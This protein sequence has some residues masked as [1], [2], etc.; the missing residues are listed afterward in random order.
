MASTSAKLYIRSA[1]FLHSK[2]KTF[3]KLLLYQKKSLILQCR[4]VCI[5][6]HYI[7]NHAYEQERPVTLPDLRLLFEYTSEANTESTYKYFTPVRMIF[8][9]IV[10]GL[11]ERKYL[12]ENLSLNSVPDFLN[13]SEVD[14]FVLNRPIMHKT[15]VHALD[16]FLDITQDGSHTRKKVPLGV[17]DY[18]RNRQ[19]TNL[20]KSVLYIIMDV[21]LWYKDL[22]DNP[23]D[24][25]NLWKGTY[26]A[27]GKV[28]AKMNK[29]RTVYVL[30]GKYELQS[31][32]DLEDGMGVAIL[33]SI[34]TKRPFEK[35]T[36]YVFNTNIVK[37]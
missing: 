37:K 21:L 18:V 3:K 15:L 9:D 25:K 2:E 11:E 17:M 26:E 31:K 19:N 34:E 12:P 16:F 1:F 7:L 29:G 8:E 23:V 24:T 22:L 6:Y 28:C 30:N 13:Q 20:Y 27:E 4:T 14:G 10:N 33:K 35:V 32:G 5:P 36:R